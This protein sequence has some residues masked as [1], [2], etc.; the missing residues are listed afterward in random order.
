MEIA[1]FAVLSFSP[2]FFWLWF[3][4]RLNK[5]RPSPKRWVGL[6]FLLGMLWSVPAYPINNATLPDDIL[7]GTLA[8]ST[9]ATSML[10]I[11]GPLEE[12]CKFLA[13]RLGAYRSSYFTEPVDGLVYSTAAAL[14]FASIENFGY[15]M[16]FGPEVLLVRGPL[17]T[18]AH[19]V[20]AS[21]WGYGL[22]VHQRSD[23]KRPWFVVATLASAAIL[24]AAYNIASFSVT[25]SWI[26]MLIVLAGGIWAYRRF[27]WGQRI[28][29]LRFRRNYPLIRC[30][31]CELNIRIIST[32]CP[33]CGTAIDGPPTGIVC[34]NCKHYNR[35]DA[36][37]CDSCGDRFLTAST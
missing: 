31:H 10:L 6:T 28:S 22:G 19:L 7:S 16:Q 9:I 11:V 25:Y 35:P 33:H 20:F 30:P 29:P 18:V 24:H 4:V 32:Y 21:L 13:V 14:G 2:G 8:M 36:L 12:T 3:Y 27:E 15:V 17:T 1:L 26:S 37:Y 34:G 5:V 23:R